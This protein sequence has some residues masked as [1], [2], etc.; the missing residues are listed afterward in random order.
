[1]EVVDSPALLLLDLPSAALAGIDLLSFTATLRFRGIKHLPPGFHFAF[2]GS[3]TAFSER[4][5]IWFEITN[6]A[7]S[8]PPLVVTR[9]DAATEALQLVTDEAD[10]LIWRANLGSVWKEGLSPYRQQA[11]R[12]ETKAEIS[13][14]P[15]LTS[16]VTSALLGRI[17]GSSTRYVSSRRARSQHSLKTSQNRLADCGFPFSK[18]RRGAATTMPRKYA[19]D[20]TS[21]SA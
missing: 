14:W 21:F 12:D 13:D 17:T 16:S 18:L 3:S 4:H 8:P 10:L 15:A 19:W 1:M 5:G 7:G 6:T 11:N 20:T 2:V 9:W